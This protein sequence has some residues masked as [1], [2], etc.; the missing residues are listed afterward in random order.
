M[1]HFSL[2]IRFY[3][4]LESLSLFGSFFPLSLSLS[5][6]LSLACV[7]VPISLLKDNRVCL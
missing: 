2:L 5:L 3:F 1:C 7:C 6:S 4:K